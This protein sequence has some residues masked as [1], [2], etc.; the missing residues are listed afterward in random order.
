MN[1]NPSNITFGRTKRAKAYST[2]EDMSIVPII[3]YAPLGSI[4]IAGGAPSFREIT[5]PR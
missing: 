5:G 3:C 2:K 4:E 1:K